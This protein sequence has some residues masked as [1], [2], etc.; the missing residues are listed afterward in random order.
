MRTAVLAHLDAHLIVIGAQR[1]NATYETAPRC[2]GGHIGRREAP[3]PCDVWNHNRALYPDVALVEHLP[4]RIALGGT[5]S[6]ARARL[7][8]MSPRAAFAHVRGAHANDA[9]APF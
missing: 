7:A 2:P 6:A 4:H 1:W 5:E 3:R 9:S 8:S